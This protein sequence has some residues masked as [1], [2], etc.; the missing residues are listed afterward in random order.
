MKKHIL[1]LL[2][3]SFFANATFAENDKLEHFL[4]TTK[5]ILYKGVKNYSNNKTTYVLR[6]KQPLD[7]EEPSK[8]YFHQLVYLTHRDFKKKTIIAIEGYSISSSN[9]YEVTQL[10]KGNQINVEHRFFGKSLPDSLNYTFL[11]LKQAS[12]D[13]HHIHEIFK[14]IYTQT[15]VSTGVSKG[16][17]TSLFYK[18]FYPTDVSACIA[19]V[20]PLANGTEDKR[21]YQFLDTVGTDVCRNKIKNLQLRLLE[22]RDKAL[23]LLQ[24]FYNKRGYDFN[25]LSFEEAYEYSVLEFS[26]G[27]WQWGK[28]CNELPTNNNSIDEVIQY[29]SATN[30]MS[31]FSDQGIKYYGPHYYQAATEMGYYGYDIKNIKQYLNAIPTNNNPSAIF[32]PN[33]IEQDFNHELIKNFKN[34][35]DNEG[36]NIIYL[37]GTLDTWSACAIT[38]SDKVNSKAFFLSNKHHGN[39]RISEMNKNEKRILNSTLKKWL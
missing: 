34:W 39:A 33:K 22:N 8:G 26:F 10:L 28:I 14:Q 19:Y 7:H 23:P 16:G 4:K 29:F 3:L 1:F 18:Y 31:L 9:Q 36:N 5:G 15:W 38:P 27:F 25:Y 12:A 13:L 37:Y 21:I 24:G 6:I 32:T 17:T 11:N 20:A 30:P 2:L 35:L